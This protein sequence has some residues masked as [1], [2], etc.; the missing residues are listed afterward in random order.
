MSTTFNWVEKKLSFELVTPLF[1]GQRE[2]RPAGLSP[3]SLKPLLRYWWRV[4][5][6]IPPD[7][8]WKQE[9]A[10]FGSLEHGQGMRV[11]PDTSNLAP[12]KQCVPP[13]SPLRLAGRIEKVQY[14][15]FG[16]LSYNR[17]T[18]GL[19]TEAPMWLPPKEFS[20]TLSFRE[21]RERDVEAAAWMLSVFGGLGRRT[22]RGFGAIRPQKGFFSLY[23]D[24]SAPNEEAARHVLNE[25]LDALEQIAIEAGKLLDDSEMPGHTSMLKGTRILTASRFCENWEAALNSLGGGFLAYRRWLGAY[26]KDRRTD[27]RPVEPGPDHE[28][29]W[30]LAIGRAPSPAPPLLATQFGLPLNSLFASKGVH[31]D[32]SCTSQRR[33]SP[34][35]MSVVGFGERQFL[36]IVA[37]FPGI[38]LPEDNLLS[39]AV[40]TEANKRN[41]QG[42]PAS[43]QGD[44][45]R[46]HEFLNELACGES[47]IYRF[48]KEKWVELW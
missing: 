30:N 9:A 18:K 27:M 16:A 44:D 10:V 25:G 36:P 37:Y 2:D 11:R 20:F 43:S 3:T 34:L 19:K 7:L 8:L 48:P 35:F 1:S 24:L 21:G 17:D 28:A 14:L 38:Y 22:R 4:L 6:P 45:E 32:E 23:P 15:G 12:S 41:P 40:Y 42:V 46:I 26:P 39:F 5:H 47:T 29:R 31:V 33:S 13:G